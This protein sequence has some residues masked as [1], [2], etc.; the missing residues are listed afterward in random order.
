MN[1]AYD[2]LTKK[3]ADKCRQSLEE[4]EE[5]FPHYNSPN[6]PPLQISATYRNQAS[7][8]FYTDPLWAE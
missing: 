6:P 5:A 7:V 8:V 1:D 4:S 2:L 3:S